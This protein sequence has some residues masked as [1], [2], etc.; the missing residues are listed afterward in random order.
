MAKVEFELLALAKPLYY[1]GPVITNYTAKK[2]KY[3]KIHFSSAA[4][5]RKHTRKFLMYL[6]K[7]F[8]FEN[9]KY[10]WMILFVSNLLTNILFIDSIHIR[11]SHVW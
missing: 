11:S 3:Q 5:L 4:G 7:I 2:W 6:L 9:N 8:S 1:M 10:Y